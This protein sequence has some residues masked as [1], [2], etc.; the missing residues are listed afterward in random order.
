MITGL[1]VTTD[2]GRPVE[3]CAPEQGVSNTPPP[4]TDGARG[5]DDP[6]TRVAL[7]KMLGTPTKRPQAQ[8]NQP[9]GTVVSQIAA[10]MK[11]ANSAQ[12]G[13]S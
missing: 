13:A 1:S 2:L 4:T 12:A 10:I 5:L 3:F 9:A 11:G 6:Q 8:Q 7:G